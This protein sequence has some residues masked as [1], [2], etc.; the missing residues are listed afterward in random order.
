MTRDRAFRGEERPST[1]DQ[2]D[3]GACTSDIKG[4]NI[5]IA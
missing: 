5:G 2:R 3:V 4:Q 1:Q